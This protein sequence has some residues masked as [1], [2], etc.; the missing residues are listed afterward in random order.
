M[1]NRLKIKKLALTS[2]FIAIGIIIPILFHSV[3]MFGKI[4]LPMH[5]PVI[6]C[7]IICGPVFGVT[8]AIMTVILSSIITGM[9]PLYPMAVIMIFEL[10]TYAIVSGVIIRLLRNRLN[11][12]ITLYI[13]LVVAMLLG[14]LI[15]GIASVIFIGILGTG[16][17]M[18]A[19]IT[20][21]FVTGLT[22]IIIQLILIPWLIIILNKAHLININSATIII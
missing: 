4:F 3:S 22:G 15:L 12:I 8:A 19:F 14:R 2:V 20:G 10:I 1:K 21:A 16:Y 11:T 17:S 5:I 6:L 9:P 13:S 7:G 18:E